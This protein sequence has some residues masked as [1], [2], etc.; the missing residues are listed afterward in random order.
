MGFGTLAG[1]VARTLGL[2]IVRRVL[3]VLGCGPTPD[4]DAVEIAVLRH[5]LAVLR[6]Q[7]PRARYA[8]A[9]RMVLAALAKLLPRERWSVFLVTPST[10][11]RWHRELVARRW[12]YPH[13]GRDRR[14]LDEE[15]VA[16]VVR[17][18]R[19]NFRWGY[20][21]IV[22]ECRRLGVR[23]SATSVR[24]ILRRHGLGPAPRR[25]GPTWT[26]FLQAQA[27]GL[28][29]VDF[30]TVETVGLTRL[31]V[32]FVVEVQRRRVH[33]AGITA[34][35]AGAWVTQQARNLLMDL[36]GHADRFR[37]LIRDR[38][39]KFTAAF[40][41][42][43]DAAGIDVVKI[44]PRAPRANAY[45]ER[46]VSTVRSECL[47]WTLVWND[48]QLYRVLTEYL[49]HYNTVRPHRSLDL[50]PPRPASRLMLVKPDTAESVRRMDVLG[51]LIHEY[52]RAA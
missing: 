31:Y 26:Q 2:M 38:D 3:G 37:F 8:P 48:R 51:G 40:D 23:V 42:V 49:R 34:H 35:P 43:F 29:A 45:A 4:A 25:G 16:L 14:G 19:E 24:R 11:L 27:S 47:D 50:Q 15:I 46:W 36:G 1:V 52:R 5:Q 10:V 32:L 13:T 39:A 28:L 20:L 18:A 12:T 41:A 33:L 44:P 21:R 7:V 9:D 17:L 30:F 22:G 6:R